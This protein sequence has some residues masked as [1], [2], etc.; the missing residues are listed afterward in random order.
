L[1][2]LQD[3]NQNNV[4]NVNNVRPDAIRHL[5][6]KKKEYPKAKIEE[7]ETNSKTKKYQGLV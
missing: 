7:L 6:G 3:P 5:R 2:W 1:Q 4:D